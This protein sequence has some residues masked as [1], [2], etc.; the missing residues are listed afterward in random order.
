MH[1]RSHEEADDSRREF[2][3]RAL[4]LGLLAGG[5]GWQLEALA[6][7][8]GELPGRLPA[9]RSVFSLQGEVRVNG[10]RAT[11]DTLIGPQDHVRTGKGASLV[12]V[13]G[14]DALIL[15]GD[16]ELQLDLGRSTRQFFRLVSGAMLTVFGQRDRELAVQTGTATIGIRGTGVYFEADP[17][18]TYVCTCYGRVQLAA[19]GDP[20]ASEEIVAQHHDAPRYVL[21]R[22][23]NGR[24]IVPAAFQWHTDLEL[25]TLE[26]LVG[27][28]VPFRLEG[29][30]YK[31]PR[32]EY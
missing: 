29:M 25:M 31:G 28:E 1:D 15:R 24:R 21:A 26:A 8:F 18:K 30:G 32:R 6:G 16:T 27:R 2:L 23:Q 5:S 20:S 17:E 11:R 10:Q 4:S 19:A 9:G 7:V 22:P 14:Q 3:V 12:A 13:V